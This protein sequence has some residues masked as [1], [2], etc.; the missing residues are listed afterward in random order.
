VSGTCD[1]EGKEANLKITWSLGSLDIDF[2][3]DTLADTWH[4]AKFQFSYNTGNDAYIGSD[5]SKFYNDRKTACYY[6]VIEMYG[7]QYIFPSFSIKVKK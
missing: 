7:I 5:T 2:E 1:R 3:Y 4:V 6:L